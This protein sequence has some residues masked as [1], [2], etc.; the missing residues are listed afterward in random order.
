MK[1]KEKANNQ[2]PN[3]REIAEDEHRFQVSVYSQPC[4]P[5][6]PKQLKNKVQKHFW[7]PNFQ[8]LVRNPDKKLIMCH[9]G[10]S[11]VFS[12]LPF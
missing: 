7:A 8:K 2:I 1:I 9:Y 5:K 4:D 12:M 6:M 3:S 10:F 11:H